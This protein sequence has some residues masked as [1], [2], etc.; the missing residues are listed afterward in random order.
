MS[1]MLRKLVI[2]KPKDPLAFM[3]AALQQP[4]QQVG[5][6]TQTGLAAEQRHGRRRPHHS[7]HSCAHSYVASVCV[8]ALRVL[9]VQLRVLVVA[10][11]HATATAVLDSAVRELGILRVRVSTLVAEEA[12]AGSALGV[13]AKTYTDAATDIP[14]QIVLSLLAA[15][16][17]K[18]DAVARGWMLE[19]FP[20]TRVT[21]TTRNRKHDGT[22]GIAWLIRRT[23]GLNG[24][25]SHSPPFCCCHSIHFLLRQ[26]QALALQA[27]GILPTHLL[28]FTTPASASA[29]GAAA[30]AAAT[31]ASASASAS[32]DPATAAA[33]ASYERHGAQVQQVFG[34]VAT[35]LDLS[36]P[37][38][39]LWE[40][41]SEVLNASPRSRA[42]KR[43]MR[44]LLLGPK[45]AGKHTQASLLSRKY[46]LLLVSASQLLRAE[47]ARTPALKDQIGQYLCNGMLV[48][49]EVVVP[50]VV[51]RLLAAD[52]KKQGFVLEGFPRTPA[53]ADALAK[54]NISPNRVVVLTVG[55]EEAAARVTGRRV[56]PDTGDVFHFASDHD[57]HASPLLSSALKD[58]LVHQPNDQAHNVEA[59]NFTIASYI[60]EL[61]ERYA[62][63]VRRVAAGGRDASTPEKLQQAKLAVF[64]QI[65]D[66]LLAPL[67]SQYAHVQA[68][69]KKTEQ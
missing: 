19:G 39:A 68:K 12:S 23:Q 69:K 8:C 41:L 26:T 53:Q 50:L 29:S 43:P 30:S 31:P 40:Q 32:A 59:I 7:I 47:M 62:R 13:Q 52:A 28:F 27:A 61:A 65:E 34:H 17:N 6:A 44:V 64:E 67:N 49:D 11:P 33:A 4:V 45:G 58:R 55:E 5:P 63:F 54:A 25:A 36:K 37:A 10:P 1:G 66:F 46:G 2:H 57:L 48:P 3:M 14:D 35:F 56:D 9:F 15:R 38:S 22:C 42:P 51:A 18:Q 21:F 24:A 16:L 60:D 20:N